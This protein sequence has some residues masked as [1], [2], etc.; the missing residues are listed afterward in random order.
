MLAGHT[1]QRWVFSV[2]VKC[3]WWLAAIADQRSLDCLDQ[4]ASLGNQV[5]RDSVIQQSTRLLTKPSTEETR[6]EVASPLERPD[7]IPLVHENALGGHDAGL[8]SFG[9]T[10]GLRLGQ[11]ARSIGPLAERA[12]KGS[13]NCHA[14]VRAALASIR[15]EAASKAPRDL[16][17]EKA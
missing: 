15:S 17:E 2:G 9:L 16:G 6:L 10:A 7:R 1:A 5:Y 12:R 11:D 14:E 3:I 8:L 13:H 4:L